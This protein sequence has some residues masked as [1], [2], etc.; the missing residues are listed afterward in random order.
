MDLAG[1]SVIQ[2]SSSGPVS[3]PSPLVWGHWG[4]LTDLVFYLESYSVI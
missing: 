1:A 4:Y 3:G 2:S